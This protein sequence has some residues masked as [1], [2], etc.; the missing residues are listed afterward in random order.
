MTAPKVIALYRTDRGRFALDESG[1]WQPSIKSTLAVGREEG[2]P[3]AYLCGLLNSELLDL[4]YAVRG[5]TPWHV[6][7]NYEPKRMNEMPYRTPH[8]D[9]RA[10]EVA[11]LVRLVAANR[12]ALLPHRAVV[13]DLDRIVKDP[14]KTGPVEIDER[15][16]LAGLAA[17]DTVSLR[18]DPTL[19]VE[20]D[21]PAPA[22]AFRHT[23]TVLELRR[24][25]KVIGRI[26]GDARRLDLLEVV[27]GGTADDAVSETLLPK[28]AVAFVGLVEQRRQTV[29]LLLGEGRELVERV[30]RL[31]CALYGVPDDLTEQVI[32]HA[33]RRSGG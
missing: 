4:W 7:R 1:A 8:G 26:T 2:A 11:D 18:L 23:R 24:G 10:D 12:R 15:A 28:D 30:E 17:K 14:W 16:L 9:P 25:K 29:Q 22:R 32:E 31:V 20:L 27:L 33:L 21:E 13:R 19:G 3:V 5:K 6:R